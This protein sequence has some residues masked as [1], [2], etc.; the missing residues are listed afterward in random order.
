M[1][2]N[3]PVKGR[4]YHTSQFVNSQFL[5]IFFGTNKLINKTHFSDT[6]KLP[7]QPKAN[8]VAPKVPSDQL[9]AQRVPIEGSLPSPRHP[10]T[11]EEFLNDLIIF[12]F[13]TSSFHSPPP[14]PI[15]SSPPPPR[16][17]IKSIQISSST[18]LFYGGYSSSLSPLNDLYSYNIRMYFLSL[19]LPLPPSLSRLLLLSPFSSPPSL[20]FPSSSSLP[21][22]IPSLPPS[23]LPFTFRFLFYPSSH[24]SFSLTPLSHSR[25]CTFPSNSSPQPPLYYYPSLPVILYPLYPSP[26]YFS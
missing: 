13:F 9:L 11:A 2:G 26:P 15:I 10:E 12:D 22:L 8:K 20:S 24:P 14:P 1:K 17:A 6:G 18:I 7:D 16:F 5:F 4:Y 23:V 19:P 3:F 21:L 25:I